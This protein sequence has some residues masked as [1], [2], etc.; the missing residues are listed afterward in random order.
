M[1]INYEQIFLI[2]CIVLILTQ[3]LSAEFMSNQE[4]VIHWRSVLKV[5]ETESLQTGLS[6]S[7]SV[8]P[9]SYYQINGTQINITGII[10]NMFGPVANAGVVL[11]KG[12]LEKPADI[13]N[14]TTDNNGEFSYSDTVNREGII[15]Y[16]ARYSSNDLAKPIASSDEVEI[17]GT[18][19]FDQNE[20]LMINVQNTIV[21]G[22]NTNNQSPSSLI[23]LTTKSLEY[24]SGQNIT[25]SGL[26]TGINGHP[27]PHAIVSLEISYSEGNFTKIGNSLS[28]DQNGTFQNSFFLTGPVSP[29]IHAVLSGQSDNAVISNEIQMTFVPD[30]IVPPVRVRSDIRHIDAMISPSVIESGEPIS[31]SGWFSDSNGEPIQSA[32]L[33][34]YWYN[35]GDQIWDRYQMSSEAITTP[36]GYFT[37]N[38][39]G[40]KLPGLSYMAIVSKYEKTGV[41]LFSSVL[42]LK[43]RDSS[44]VTS[45]KLFSDLIVSSSP[46]VV[47]IG[48][49]SDI[50]FNLTDSGGNPLIGESL[51]LFFSMDGFTWLM[52][53]NETVTNSEG[54]VKI[55]DTPRQSGFHYYKGIFNG[56]QNFAPVQSETLVLPVIEGN[57]SEQN[58]EN[59]FLSESEE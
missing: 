25:F 18:K 29:I 38:V 40:P 6:I 54:I 5:P 51:N 24:T 44:K 13:A 8:T 17:K 7:L 47:S 41:P 56:S 1:K 20:T 55:S 48:E 32:R 9:N 21:Q 45:G 26:V 34:L 3:G 11:A 19:N 31:I 46:D 12:Y 23:T 42:F 30:D 39:S 4:T 49:Q 22:T 16:K 43:T 28:T 53:G 2:I 59:F 27:L 33:N 15:R 57:R 58:Q 36:D 10:R 37:F 14:L 52:N 35:F 50:I